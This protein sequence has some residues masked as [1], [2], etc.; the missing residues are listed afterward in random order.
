MSDYIKATL[1]ATNAG[2]Y[3]HC[4]M[5]ARQAM[6]AT[7][8]G[9]QQHSRAEAE[10]AE[11]YNIDR[12]TEACALEGREL[13]DAIWAGE[14]AVRILGDS[15]WHVAI[16]RSIDKTARA[17]VY[18]DQLVDGGKETLHTI[19]DFKFTADPVLPTDPQMLATAAAA[20]RRDRDVSGVRII[21]I[22]G[23]ARTVDT[24]T[25]PAEAMDWI[26]DHLVAGWMREACEAVPAAVCPTWCVHCKRR[27]E[28]PDY[29]Q[30]RDAIL[31]DETQELYRRAYE[32]M[33]DVAEVVKE[34]ASKPEPVVIREEI[35]ADEEIERAYMSGARRWYIRDGD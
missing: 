14:K 32:V 29:A 10:V 11:A 27:F 35:D 3:S 30:L 2:R 25:I 26:A 12:K 19:I 28:C 33:E 5:G 20:W 22:D 17:D 24:E 18:A 4:P 31:H 8:R 21:I 1:A 23:V 6:T 9:K 15:A 16:E 34:E 13:D 7:E